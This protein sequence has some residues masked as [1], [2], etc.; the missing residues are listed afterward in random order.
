MPLYAFIGRDGPSGPELRKHHR[1]AHLA[2]IRALAESGRVRFAGPLRDDGGAPIGSL[3][4]FEADTLDAAREIGAADPYVVEGIFE[5]WQ[6]NETL[7]VLAE[8]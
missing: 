2:G 6:V 8:S 5:S 7:D 4:L 3:V 1:P